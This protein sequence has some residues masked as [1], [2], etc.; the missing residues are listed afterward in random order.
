[1]KGLD[2][3]M[4]K[5]ISMILALVLCTGCLAA[6]A[7]GEPLKEEMPVL[8]VTFTYP[9]AFE[10]ARGTIGTDGAMHLDGS[11][12]LAYWY[13]GAMT[14]EKFLDMAQED[15][16]ALSEKLRIL[17]YVFSV[18]DGMSFTDA[19]D[20]INSVTGLSLTA[21]KGIQIGQ[22]ENWTFW[23]Y[24]NPDPA[25]AATLDTEFLNEYSALFD[26]KDEIAAGFTCS[27]PFNEYGEMDGKTVRFEV[28]DLDGNPVS[29]E[30]IFGEHEITMVNIWATW[31]GP[32]V[33]ELAELQ[34]IHTRFLEKDCAVL[35]LMTDDN[36]EMAKQLIDENGITYRVVLSQQT[37]SNLFPF[38]AVPT[39]FFVDRSGAFLG[40]KI[41]GAL[42]DEYEPALEPLLARAQEKAQP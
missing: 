33:G 37:L 34:A 17:F 26:L 19:C 23:L 22:E 21:E 7:E 40:T 39:S 8:G 11:I 9:Q 13:Y 18:G 28:T 35:G 36:V 27:V 12:Y 1:M 3:I 32:C 41:T 5:L 31:C 25:F 10:N 6:G 4:K 30:E 29:T 42:T 14:K 24:M 15:P 16:T 20:R 2:Y 38:E